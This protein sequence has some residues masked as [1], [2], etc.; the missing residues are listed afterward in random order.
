MEET[1]QEKEE[2][3]EVGDND[4]HRYVIP[5]ERLYD[6]DEF[7]NDEDDYDVPEWAEYI[8]G[9]RIIFCDYRVE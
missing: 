1:Y 3:T 4:G 9:G 5:Y 6:W 7:I 8:D 2:F